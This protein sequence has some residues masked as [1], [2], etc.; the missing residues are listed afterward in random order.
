[1]SV[2]ELSLEELL[3]LADKGLE[4]KLDAKDKHLL[5][6]TSVGR[7]VKERNL[8]EGDTFVPTFVIYY[9]YCQNWRPRGKKLSKIEFFRQFKHFFNQVRK[10]TQRY[11]L[12][13]KELYDL[14]KE[15][16]E[17]AKLY[18]KRRE[19]QTVKKKKREVPSS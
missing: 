8:M 12:M 7:Y 16:Q 9:D 11:Y 19:S 1:M 5:D 14:T 6:K 15:G 3:E 4:S 17:R 2:K 10:S 18:V 13:D